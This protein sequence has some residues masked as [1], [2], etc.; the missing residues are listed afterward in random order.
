MY[1]QSRTRTGPAPESELTP[2]APTSH[3]HSWTIMTGSGEITKLRQG[4]AGPHEPRLPPRRSAPI[5]QSGR[6]PGVG[7]EP[8]PVLL[9]HSGGSIS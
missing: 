2:P 3:H 7:P 6:S 8:G 4:P 1:S 9:N 5:G